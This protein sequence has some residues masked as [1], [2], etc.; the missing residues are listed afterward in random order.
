MIEIFG[1]IRIEK[2]NHFAP[3]QPLTHWVADHHRCENNCKNYV[4]EAPL[5]QN[6][7]HITYNILIP[8]A[9]NYNEYIGTRC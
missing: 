8:H 7:Y 9:I 1:L 5:I 2:Y 4:R 3:I 6:I